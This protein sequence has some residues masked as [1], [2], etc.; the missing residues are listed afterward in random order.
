MRRLYLYGIIGTGEALNLVIRGVDGLAPVYAVVREGLGAVVSAYTGEAPRALPRE[1]LVR[2]LFAHQQVVERVMHDHTVLP[3]QFG[4]VLESAQEVLDLLAQGHRE[5]VAALASIRDRVE[6][7]VAATWSTDQVLQEISREDAV[8]RARE[9]VALK[10][11]PTL[12][13]RV[14]LGQLVKARLDQRRDSYRD[15]MVR[16]LSPLA[17]DVAPNALVSDELVM[18]VAFLV[19]QHRQREFDAAVEKLDELF[20]SKIF[21]RV[22]GP[23]PPYS[24]SSVAVTRVTPEQVEEAQ[25]ALGLAGAPSQAEVR[26][27]YRRLAAQEHRNLRPEV[28]PVSDRL[29]GLRRAAELLVDHGR[30]RNEAERGGRNSQDS[31][32][33]DRLFLIAIKRTA[34]DEIDPARFGGTITMAERS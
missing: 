12:E 16:L 14:G 20:Q 32:A 22:I 10:G 23:L 30:A 28:G 18:N 1:T 5:F 6:I 29:A 19:E 21:F 25:R 13:D 2:C 33:A 27:A 8:V 11:Q 3:M 7:E 24:F 9:A 26:K 17:V 34:S 15:Q 31:S 4:T